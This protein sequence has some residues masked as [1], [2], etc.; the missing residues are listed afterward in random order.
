MKTPCPPLE[1]KGTNPLDGAMKD[2]PGANVDPDMG[3]SLGNPKP[4]MKSG[5]SQGSVH[6]GEDSLTE[7]V[8]RDQFD[9]TGYYNDEY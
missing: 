9:E 6:A 2:N 1:G 5:Y 4:N 7:G 3:K 8:K